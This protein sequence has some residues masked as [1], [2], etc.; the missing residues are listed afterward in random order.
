MERSPNESRGLQLARWAG[1]LG[2][3]IALLLFVNQV[4]NEGVPWSWWKIWLAGLI[5]IFMLLCIGLSV[6]SHRALEGRDPLFGAHGRLVI[7]MLVVA[8]LCGVVGFAVGS[9]RAKEQPTDSSA[10]VRRELKRVFKKLRRTGAGSFA[11]A[12]SQSDP[13]LYRTRARKLGAA[14]HE[15]AAELEEVESLRGDRTLTRLTGLFRGLGNAYETLGEA[16]LSAEDRPAEFERARQKVKSLG[17]KL[18]AAE[19]DLSQ[20]GILI[21]LP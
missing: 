19:R 21:D 4:G 8:G 15:A 12:L 1:I 20:Q 16:V 3:F 11:S 10:E 14:F 13:I 7:A 6:E 2:A 18:Q 17:E 9:E 5:F